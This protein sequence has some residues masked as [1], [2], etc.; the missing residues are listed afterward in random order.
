MADIVTVCPNWA[1]RIISAP[2]G[3]GSRRWSASRVALVLRPALSTSACPLPSLCSLQTSRWSPFSTAAPQPS[4]AS[5]VEWPGLSRSRC[6]PRKCT[7]KGHDIVAEQFM[8]GMCSSSAWRGWLEEKEATLI[9]GANGTSYGVLYSTT[10][11]GNCQYKR[12]PTRAACIAL[13][14][15]RSSC[16][17]ASRHWFTHSDTN[18][19]LHQL[20]SLQY[21]YPA[22]TP[23]SGKTL[24]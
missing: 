23:S 4:L 19:G 24:Y 2:V 16:T 5:R 3:V 17:H 10:N 18:A 20:T 13:R 15:H 21:L 6:P 12:M 8:A 9:L 22:R 1:L 14:R 7:T 11:G